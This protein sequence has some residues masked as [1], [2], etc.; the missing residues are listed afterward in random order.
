MMWL[1]RLLYSTS[2]E[3][4][5]LEELW[6]YL[7]GKYFSVDMGRYEHISIGSGSLVTLQ[8]VVL[9]ICVGIIIA[10]AMACY[11]KNKLG[12]FVRAIVKEQA[13][14]PDKAMTVY[15]LGFARNSAVKAS[16]RSPNKLGKI[17]HCVEKEAYDAK[18]AEAREAYI[19]EHGNEEGF[20]M[21]QYRMDFDNDHFYIPD[22]E[23]YRAEVRFDNEGS[24]WRAFILVCIVAIVSAALIC[25][26]LPDMI[27]LVDNMIGILTENDKILK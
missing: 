4:T 19:V 13:L 17:V 18:V 6:E 5:L 11:D 14:W 9:G 26:L 25:F 23:H 15:D 22:E 1:N 7:E 3:P 20:F 10:A 24:G 12:A 21:P 27:Q 16:L 8:K 2:G